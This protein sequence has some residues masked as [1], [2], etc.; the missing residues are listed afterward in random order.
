MADSPNI[1]PSRAKL[2]IRGSTVFIVLD[3]PTE[4]DAQR[5]FE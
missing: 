4:E 2:E 5:A 3:F 1:K